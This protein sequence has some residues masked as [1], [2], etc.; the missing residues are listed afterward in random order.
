MKISVVIPIYNAEKY[1]N[2]CL[3]SIKEQSNFN[4]LEIIIVNDESIDN[5]KK[6]ISDFKKKNKNVIV[7]NIKHS[8]VS[9]ARNVGIDL[10]SNKY[11]SF[12]DAD[13]YI[14]P[15]Y[16]TSI[17]KE[18][19]KNDDSL[20]VTGFN[21]KYENSK[22]K[23]ERIVKQKKILIGDQIIS[24]FLCTNDIGP[25]VYNK[26]F[27]TKIAKKIKFDEG[28]AIAEDKW[29][30]FQYLTKIK[31]VTILP[32]GKYNYIINKDSVFMQSFNKKK[33]D[34][35]IIS[36]RIKNIIEKKYSNLI[37]EFYSYDIDVK[38]RVYSDLCYSKANVEFKNEYLELKKEINNYPILKKLKNS[39]FK[40]FMAFVLI[41][42]SPKLYSFVQKNLKLQYKI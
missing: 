41:R 14:D 1:L 6:I 5:S 39:N 34:S 19:N 25:N 29:F 40:H 42:I 24:S 9:K 38:T 17:I 7:K 20:I 37:D 35:I 32:I 8:G 10:A 12:L 33:L 27:L 3:N 30:V 23:I 15:D 18:I 2:R 36:N 22:V 11:I 16:Y 28:I 4:D 31:K 21:V 13:D 26:L